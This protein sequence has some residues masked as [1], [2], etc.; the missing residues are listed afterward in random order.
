MVMVL[1]YGHI[2]SSETYHCDYHN[3]HDREIFLPS[4][5]ICERF[6]GIKEAERERKI[7]K[8]LE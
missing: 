1:T 7:N 8:I 4:Q 2:G 5:Q 6:F 3:L